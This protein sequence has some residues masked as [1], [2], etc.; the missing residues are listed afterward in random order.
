MQRKITLTVLSLLLFGTPLSALAIT[1]IAEDTIAGLGTTVTVSGARAGSSIHAAVTPPDGTTQDLTVQVGAD[2]TSNLPVAP[3][4]T[5]RAGTYRVTVQGDNGD[6]AETSFL[7][8]PDSVDATMST[9]ESDRPRIA[10]D[11]SD[12]T[13]I[14]VRLR[15]RHGNVLPDR[16]VTLV[17]SRPEDRIQAQSAQTD[18]SGAQHFIAT[19]DLPGHASIRAIDLLSGDV[20]DGTAEIDVGWGA[21]AGGYDTGYDTAFYSPSRATSGYSRYLAQAASFDVIDHFVITAPQTL[22]RGEEAPKIIVR[23]VDRGERT[24]EDYAG[25]IVFSSTDPDAVLPNFGEYTFKPRDLGQKEF[26][27]VLTFQTLGQQILRIEDKNDSRILGEV[28]IDVTGS[29]EGSTGTISIDEPKD[30]ATVSAATVTVAGKG[31]A[32]ANLLI[33]GGAKDV[34][35]ETDRDG[36]FSGNVQVPAGVKEF[37]VHVR[38]DSGRNTSDPVRL[39]IDANAPDVGAITFRPEQPRAGEEVLATVATEP[40][41]PDVTLTIGEGAAATS[42]QLRENTASPGSYQAFFS[43]PDAGTH[44]V[45]VAVKDTAGNTREIRTTLQVQRSGLPVV[46][47]VKAQGRASAVA[48]SW[49]AA[50]GTVDGYRIFIGEQPGTFSYT[51]ETGKPT[52]KATVAGLKAGSIYYFAVKAVR[53][54]LESLE[55]SEVVSAQVLGLSL[56]VEP[57]DS[58]LDLSWTFP[59]DLPLQSFRLEYGAEGE[60]LTEQRLIN[61]ELR[62]FS[63]H[64]LINGI[65]YT[66]RLTPITVAGDILEDLAATGR[67]TPSGPPGFRAGAADPAPVDPAAVHLPGQPEHSKEG[68]PSVIILTLLIAA[69]WFVLRRTA[70][71]TPHTAVHSRH[72]S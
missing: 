72:R 25:T 11:G 46:T 6:Q 31:P 21:P 63:M 55:L 65:P 10:A 53:G 61:G 71:Q 20:I 7:V 40:G 35:V 9:V 33:S 22:P 24:V 4:S 30:G 5:T 57:A 2:G 68:L 45:R 32:F 8:A 66:I 38:D 28:T 56:V 16:P 59:A 69:A 19:S 70:R 29:N 34:T 1:A 54:D 41:T 42:V 51:L 14:T 52:T 48:L 39:V 13:I 12:S 60:S 43:A 26:P 15:D 18:T 3:L 17:S 49:D 44:P 36:R 27:L 67:G 58:A 23:A 62:L 37:T 47:G 64:D 50:P